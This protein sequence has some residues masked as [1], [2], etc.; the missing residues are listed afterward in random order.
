MLSPPEDERVR[1]LISL[2]HSSKGYF[3]AELT[4]FP[5]DE[6]DEGRMTRILMPNDIDLESMKSPGSPPEVIH[7]LEGCG[8]YS[9]FVP[10]KDQA[11]RSLPQSPGNDATHRMLIRHPRRFAD[12]N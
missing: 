5:E 8:V 7:R 1:K 9:S 12:R 3:N 6:M 11:Q 10:G 4:N 2:Q